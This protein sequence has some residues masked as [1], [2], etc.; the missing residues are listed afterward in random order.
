[1]SYSSHECIGVNISSKY[2]LCWVCDALFW[3][4][5]TLTCLQILC[6]ILKLEDKDQLPCFG[7]LVVFK[8]VYKYNG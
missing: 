4:S 1:M 3:A 8:Y 7:P 5:F 2:G 6:H